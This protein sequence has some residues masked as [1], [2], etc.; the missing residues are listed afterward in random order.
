MGRDSK[1]KISVS[2][3]R[4]TVDKLDEYAR[5]FN[6]SRSSFVDLM[7]TQ[8]GQVLNVAGLEAKKSDAGQSGDD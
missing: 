1:V 8:I 3:A 2:L 6:L 5:A 4:D 7:V